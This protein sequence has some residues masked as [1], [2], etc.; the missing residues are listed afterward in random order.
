MTRP[1]IL[2]SMTAAVAIA[3]AGCA[4][5]DDP[6]P[7]TP[8]TSIPTEA[9]PVPSPS[10]TDGPGTWVIS[11]DAF[12][13][14]E[15]GA[16]LRPAAEFGV[17]LVRDPFAEPGESACFST[18]QLEIDGLP[19][20]F[21]FAGDDGT[22]QT[23]VWSADLDLA[24]RLGPDLPLPRTADGISLGTGDEVVADLLG[25]PTYPDGWGTYPVTWATTSDA[26]HTHFTSSTP[27]E[28]EDGP[29]WLWQIILYTDDDGLRYPRCWN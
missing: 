16:P 9:L 13:P 25:E 21:M 29:G 2:I 7:S 15:I 5:T 8:E 20:L 18:E 22:V 23:I 14:L 3:L 19:G 6:A 12:G 11:A 10:P 1:G 28:P 27:F 17:E 4:A 24:A 26:V